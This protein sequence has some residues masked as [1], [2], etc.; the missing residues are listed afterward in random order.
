APGADGANAASS[1]LRVYVNNFTR[2]LENYQEDLRAL[3]FLS[4][5]SIIDPWIFAILRPPVLRLIHSVL[6]CEMSS[7]TKEEA[8][9]LAIEQGELNKQTDLCGQ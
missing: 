4:M 8:P 9:T 6:C 5:N 2:S 7:K 3:R 1:L